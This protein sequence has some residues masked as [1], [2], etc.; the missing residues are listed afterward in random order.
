MG[1]Q[2]CVCSRP[3]AA[4]AIEAPAAAAGNASIMTQ[5]LLPQAW[6]QMKMPLAGRRRHTPANP[7][8]LPAWMCSMLPTALSATCGHVGRWDGRWQA[9]QKPGPRPGW[10][11]GTAC[12]AGLHRAGERRRRGLRTI[13]CHAAL[14][15][16]RAA[17]ERAQGGWLRDMPICCTATP[18]AFPGLARKKGPLHCTAATAATPPVPASPAYPCSPCTA[19][20]A[21]S[22]ARLPPRPRPCPS[23]SCP[24]PCRPCRRARPADTDAGKEHVRARAGLCVCVQPPEKEAQQ[25][26]L[27]WLGCPAR[28]VGCCLSAGA[29]ALARANPPEGPGV[30]IVAV[31]AKHTT[32]CIADDR[33]RAAG[34]GNPSAAAA[35]AAGC[36]ARPPS[37]AGRSQEGGVRPAASHPYC[38]ASFRCRR[39]HPADIAM[40][41]TW[42]ATTT[43]NSN[44]PAARTPP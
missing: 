41:H 12:R 17:R 8:L 29:S 1:T 37:Q 19:Q 31:L 24:W 9:V 10:G 40:T 30:R 4:G 6:N 27:E 7:K 13:T 16:A 22:A 5:A 11:G 25:G 36:N 18:S 39:M 28:R 23:P 21:Q 43:T 14:P 44:R 33:G 35:A 38:K 34:Q 32:A 2:A 20:S 42:H 26:P 3:T 15:L